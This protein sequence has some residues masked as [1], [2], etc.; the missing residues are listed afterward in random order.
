MGV[1]DLRRFELSLLQLAD[2]WAD[3]RTSVAV[4]KAARDAR[5]AGR[6]VGPVCRNVAVATT[7]WNLLEAVSVVDD[8]GVRVW[9]WRFYREPLVKKKKAKP[10]APPQKKSVVPPQKKK[11]INR[12][13]LWLASHKKKKKVV[14]S[15]IKSPPPPRE[16]SPIAGLY[17]PPESPVKVVKE[18]VVVL[19]KSPPPRR[20]TPPPK[21]PTP[22]PTPPDPHVKELELMASLRPRAYTE[23]I[24]LCGNQNFTARSC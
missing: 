10:V 21:I 19:A 2:A 4:K 16:W 20:K 14:E 13:P 8:D 22:P 7:L 5:E 9:R 17:T 11:T 23:R 6:R 12:A 15:P 1:V 18:T 3:A 24:D